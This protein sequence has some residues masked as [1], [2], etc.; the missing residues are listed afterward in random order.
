MKTGRS[1]VSAIFALFFFSLGVGV[2]LFAFPLFAYRS[3]F[4]SGWLG[5]V[6]SGY[7]LG[8]LVLSPLAGTLADRYG[9]RMLLL[10]ATWSAA[11]FSLSYFLV[12]GGYTL[13]AIQL[14]LGLSSGIVKPVLLAHLA[15]ATPLHR[16]GRAFGWA[17]TAANLVFF[18]GP[19]VGGL[20]YH[21][22]QMELIVASVIVCMVL[23]ALLFHLFFAG[24]KR[25]P[26]LSHTKNK[27]A[28]G[29]Q[30][31][32]QD[33]SSRIPLFPL[34]LAVFGRTLGI[35]VLL[36]FFP[37]LLSQKLVGPD[38]LIGLL[39]ALPGGISSLLL[40]LTGQ[41]ADRFSQ[42]IL[43]LT[44][45]VTSAVALLITGY[46]ASPAAFAI[47]GMAMGVGT[48]LSLPS[49]MARAVQGVWTK[50]KA[51]GIFQMA[52]SSGFLVGPLLS[53][54][55]VQWSASAA[56]GIVF[57]GMIGILSC[58]PF[59]FAFTK[60]WKE[61]GFLLAACCCF[62]L[63]FFVFPP[64][65]S[66]LQRLQG[67]QSVDEKLNTFANLAMGGIVHLKMVGADDQLA[68]DAA[69]DA[70]ATIAR[71]EEDF[72]H[73]STTGS[74]GR[75]NRA[76]G[77]AP[78]AVSPAAFSLID[79]ALRLGADSA[80]VFDI[81]V[82]AVTV[83]PLYYRTQ[84]SADKAALVDYRKVVLEPLHH[85]VFLPKTGM[86]LDLGGLAKGSIV[87]AAAA[88]VRQA[89]VASALIEAS[90][91]FFCYG[92][93]IWKV[94]IQDPRADRLL[95]VIEVQNAGVCGSGDY[96]Q[97]DPSSSDAESGRKHHILDPSELTSAHASIAVTVIA[98]ST[99]LADALATTLFIMGPERGG[100]FLKKYPGCSALWV[101]PDRK[102]VTSAGFPP[103]IKVP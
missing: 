14:W 9:S 45:M 84:A 75:V 27:E 98:P 36:V 48:A 67:S 24:E 89:G 103:F 90:G 4:A 17:G 63:L 95:G 56:T 58:V 29:A 86:A 22:F 91:D 20:L 88:V 92:D 47:T 97:Y 52:A 77:K 5:L 50:G 23:A 83:L 10:F 74:I 55:L 18:L 102:I 101:L 11:A 76:A 61:A 3:Y 82:G 26:T 32:A 54:L 46:C 1:V 60:K 81:T 8:R 85:T 66:S 71:L 13:F 49:S 87:D 72:G 73:R 28:E 40:P 41:L 100:K 62:V 19:A 44:G 43:I 68:E 65:H 7:F 34:F 59:T 33:G 64:E 25:C 37:I 2:F 6:F 96:Y 16:Q 93:R 21:F 69:A 39:V 57:A 94:G 53:G 99:E 12:P 78:V 31:K 42:E 38:W 15:L 30:K 70:F 35:S 79:R 80:G 51:M